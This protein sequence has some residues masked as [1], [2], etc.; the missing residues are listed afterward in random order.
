MTIIKCKSVPTGL[1]NDEKPVNRFVHI[2]N[3]TAYDDTIYGGVSRKSGQPFALVKA[4]G[5][6]IF[7]E[8][9]E[10]LKHGYRVEL[11]QM[12]AFLSIPGSVESVSAESRR[13][14]A[15]ALSV[16]LVA[17]GD[18]KTCCQGPEFVIENVTKGATV[19]VDGVIGEN[20]V[21]DVLMN[22]TDVLVHSTG[23][24]FYMSDVSDP[25]V[26]A[27][28]AGSDGKVLVKAI[29]TEST[30]TTLTCTFPQ[31]D[32]EEGTYRFCV[33]SRNGLDPAQYGVTIGSR[34][35]RVVNEAPSVEE[36]Q[37]GQG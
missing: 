27:Y 13:A 20:Q 10:N 22:G 21:P 16:H 26:G 6:M 33:A 5:T 28:I 34:N 9:G 14:S 37:D 30:A 4:T 29:V 11:P 36:V 15:P 3:G 19:I 35:I 1:E 23:R 12:S 25:T 17:K 18:L 32:L 2:N 31:I 8:I 7:D 24:G